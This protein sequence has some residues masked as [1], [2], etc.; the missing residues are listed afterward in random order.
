[1][2]TFLRG[3]L[4]FDDQTEAEADLL[5]RIESGERIPFSERRPPAGEMSV[6]D[7]SEDETIEIPAL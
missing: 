1:M 2:S 4:P 6:T 5:R 7:G 3:A